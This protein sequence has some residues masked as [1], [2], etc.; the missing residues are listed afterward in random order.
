MSFPDVLLLVI[1]RNRHHHHV[2]PLATK[3]D[4]ATNSLTVPELFWT[5]D[6]ASCR[7]KLPKAADRHSLP[8]NFPITWNFCL[9]KG[10]RHWSAV[11]FLCTYFSVLW[12]V[13]WC[14]W[15][16]RVIGKRGNI[17]VGMN[18]EHNGYLPRSVWSIQCVFVTSDLWMVHSVT[19]WLW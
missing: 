8:M 7:N 17:R 5:L 9:E 12:Q 15:A 3:R 1:Q 14:V 2:L 6:P 10:F 19:H 18:K 11:V 16:H 4:Y 13:V